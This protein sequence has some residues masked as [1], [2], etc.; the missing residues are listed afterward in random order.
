MKHRTEILLAALLLLLA[1]G[2]MPAQKTSKAHLTSL[3]SATLAGLAGT[4]GSDNGLE[5]QVTPAADQQFSKQISGNI[6]PARVPAAHVPRPAGNLVVPPDSNFLLGFA[7]INHRAQR[8]ASAGNQFS[9]EPPDQG[10][11]V[12]GG[13]VLETVNSAV[14]LYSATTGALL[15]GPIGINEFFGLPPAI[16]RPAPFVFGPDVTDPRVYY[17]STTG[18]WFLTAGEIDRNSATGQFASPGHSSVLIAVSTTSSPLFYNLFALDTTDDTGTPDHAGCPCLA[19]QPLIGADANGFYV[20]TNEFPIFGPGFNGAQIYAMSKAAL[21]AGVLPPSVVHFSGLPLAEGPA[22]SVQPATVPPGGSFATTNGGIE[23]FLSAL[24]FT[25]TLDNRIAVWALTNTSSLTSVTPSVVLSSLVISSEVYGQPPDAQQQP[26]PTP[27]AD[28]LKEHLELLAA[29]DDRMQQTVFAGGYLW[30]A[31]NSVVKTPNG[32]VRVGSAYFIVTPSV[33]AGG[34][35]SATIANQGYVSVNQENLLF[36]SIGVNA[37]GK[38]VVTFT[39]VGPDSFPSIAYAPID[40]VNGAGDVRLAAAG[41]GP[42]DGFSGYHAYGG[43]RTG[44]W[45]DYTA[46][47]AD[48]SGDIWFAAEYIPGGPRTALANWGTFIGKAAP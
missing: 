4:A 18:R 40:A 25:A 1:A 15:A 48:S 24:D 39:L 26:G 44:R 9:T 29:N 7:G 45:G 46:A 10:L 14:A 8:L 41:A 36:P 37:A 12:G 20:S 5:V 11:A 47:V 2:Q 32:P 3:G 22:Y 19:D 16:L 23:Y 27:L 30:S 17:D 21:A 13:Y 31:L 28:S 33:S 34:V 35:L 43:A 6:S 42:D 38:G